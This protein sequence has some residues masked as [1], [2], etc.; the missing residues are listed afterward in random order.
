MKKIK[1]SAVL[2]ITASMLL[3]SSCKKE[4]PCNCGVITND[5]IETSNGE[6]YYTLTIKNDCSGNSQKFYFDYN[7]WLNAPVGQNFC[8]TNVS[9]WMPI[10]ETTIEQVENKEII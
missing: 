4:K 9:T 2:F 6:L 8:V 3:F 10:G 1:L 7:T 5:D